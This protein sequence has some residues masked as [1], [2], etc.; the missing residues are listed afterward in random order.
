MTALELAAFESFRFRT[1]L[2][3]RGSLWLKPMLAFREIC[4]SLLTISELWV[5]IIQHYNVLVLDYRC[6][7]LINYKLQISFS[8]LMSARFLI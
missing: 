5:L 7:I 6:A 2:W 8:N 4:L 1:L 3:R